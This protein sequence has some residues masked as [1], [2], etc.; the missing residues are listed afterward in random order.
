MGIDFSTS[1]VP[2]TEKLDSLQVVYTLLEH[3]SWDKIF[4]LK[5]SYL[6]R[7]PYSLK[8]IRAKGE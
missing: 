6:I 2:S 3:N 7:E 5:T 1:P 8:A 4:Y